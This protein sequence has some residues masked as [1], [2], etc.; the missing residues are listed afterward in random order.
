MSK[1]TFRTNIDIAKQLLRDMETSETSFQIGDRI[2]VQDGITMVVCGRTW[3]CELLECHLEVEL[4]NCFPHM[5][6]SEF[7]KYVKGHGYR[8]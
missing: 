6:I 3:N 7:E 5:T 4:T 8:A 2:V 1:T